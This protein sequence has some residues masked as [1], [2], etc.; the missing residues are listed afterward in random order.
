MSCH[1][2]TKDKGDLRLDTRAFAIK[3][4]DIGTSLVPGKPLESTLYT[5]SIL[6]E[7]HDDVMPPAKAMKKGQVVTYKEK[8]LLRKW[9]EQGAEW[10]ADVSLKPKQRPTGK[11]AKVDILPSELYK[12]LG[13]D[14]L[15]AKYRKLRIIKILFQVLQQNMRWLLFLVVNSPWVVQKKMSFQSVK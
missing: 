3:G 11:V 14:K 15:A 13:F 9:I 2:P 6:P 5:L 1:G 7:D 4:G 10:P 12:K 8:A